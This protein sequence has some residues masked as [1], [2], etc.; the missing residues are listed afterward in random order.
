MRGFQLCIMSGA[1]GWHETRF[2][3]FQARS[4]MCGCVC[5][6]IYI[7]IYIYIDAGMFFWA[8]AEWLRN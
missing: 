5:V 7:Y 2:K 8:R 6:S 1:P 4:N 3:R